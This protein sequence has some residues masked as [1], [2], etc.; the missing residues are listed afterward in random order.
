MTQPR[1]TAFLLAL[2]GA[3]ATAG[4]A[5]AAWNNVFQVCCNDCKPRV[6]FS[7]PCPDPCPP[8]CPQ[9]EM[10]ISYVQRCY[11]QPV[12]EYAVGS[13]VRVRVQDPGGLFATQSYGVEADARRAALS[14]I[15]SEK[16]KEYVGA[17][18]DDTFEGRES[19]SRGEHHG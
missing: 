13:R 14:S 12:T 3:L 16:G 15:T 8:P 18:A 7:A 17:L 1:F 5:P 4:S 10:R 6:S 9:P 11:Y 2:G 19:G